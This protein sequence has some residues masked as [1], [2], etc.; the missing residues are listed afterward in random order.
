MSCMIALPF[1]PGSRL[2]FHLGNTSSIGEAIVSAQ[3][4]NGTNN[5][6]SPLKHRE[7]D[8]D[9]ACH[10]LWHDYAR[11]SRS[12]VQKLASQSKQLVERTTTDIFETIEKI[13][14]Q[15]TW[16]ECD[17]IPRVSFYTKPNTSV[18]RL[19]TLLKTH[20]KPI[21][22]FVNQLP[23]SALPP[24]PACDLTEDDCEDHFAYWFNLQQEFKKLNMDAQDIKEVVPPQCFKSPLF[25]KQEP[26]DGALCKTMNVCHLLSSE[27]VVLMYW[28]PP[29]STKE[30]CKPSSQGTMGISKTEFSQSI[31]PP[32]VFSTTAITFQ[33][34]DLYLRTRIVDGTTHTLPRTFIT[35]SVLYGNWTFTSPSLYLAHHA[36]TASFDT[37]FRRQQDVSRWS[38]ITRTTKIR[39][40][41]V[42]T[43]DLENVFTTLHTQEDRTT[44]GGMEYASM[45]AKG[46]FR[47]HSPNNPDPIVALKPLNLE[48]LE[49]PV[50]ADVYYDARKDD[51]WGEQ[52]HC[53]TMTA[54]HHRPVLILLPD[55][56]SKVLNLGNWSYCELWGLVDPPIRLTPLTASTVLD[57]PTLLPL[58]AEVLQA[59]PEA[60]ENSAQVPA[61]LLV[62]RPPHVP[63]TPRP[64]PHSPMPNAGEIVVFPN[65]NGRIDRN[66][67][68]GSTSLNGYRLGY[69]ET[70]GYSASSTGG[71]TGSDEN[72]RKLGGQGFG[73]L[74]SS[75]DQA[76]PGVNPN[77]GMND[78]N[79]NWSDKSGNGGFSDQPNGVGG[80]IPSSSAKKADA[81]MMIPSLSLGILTIL[82]AFW[83]NV[84]S[85]N[86]KHVKL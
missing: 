17:G 37:I 23:K 73:Y 45:V 16:T 59:T 1:Q 74:G 80:K 29:I 35:S 9:K 86:T 72:R 67:N 63:P 28:P 56:L 20:Y 71:S 47:N 48:D 19:V 8:D 42:F 69:F 61:N 62:G 25:Q 36:F 22:V 5:T 26:C 78:A 77:S 7:P 54:G 21:S 12:I 27:E 34:Q 55:T 3:S 68:G 79:D 58:T 51:C 85:F 66:K 33:G 75:G 50:P 30:L 52:S 24:E 13:G 57:M 14:P 53:G 32:A 81:T 18:T 60:T 40:A 31:V 4:E 43:V 44:L 70:D 84:S 76:R 64:T 46:K 6:E 11:E 39:E 10:Y 2:T 65:G 49:E 41:G 82:V 38:A 15:K 83:N